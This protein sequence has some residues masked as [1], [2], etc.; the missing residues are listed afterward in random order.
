MRLAAAALIGFASFALA[1]ALA[2]TIL[3]AKASGGIS[4]DAGGTGTT[5]TFSGGVTRGLGSP[6]FS[7]SGEATV[8][9]ASVAPDLQRTE[10]ELRH[11]AQYW[12]SG[13]ELKLVLYR[14]REGDKLH[15][16]VTVTVETNAVD[17]GSFAGTYVLDVRDVPE[18]GDTK[19]F[20]AE[21][22]IECFAE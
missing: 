4:C 11:V 14:E 17:E 2:V 12:L 6:L 8:R 19:E 13:N 21:G 1:G 20:R 7:F 16:E 10:F 5:V 3:P 9:D 22:A 15:G 18:T